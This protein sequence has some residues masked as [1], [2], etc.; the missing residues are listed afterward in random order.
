MIKN[1]VIKA[2]MILKNIYKTV[3]NLTYITTF[4]QHHNIVTTFFYNYQKIRKWKD[5]IKSNWI[6]FILLINIRDGINI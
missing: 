3:I 4:Y 1:I 5:K 2:V 6:I